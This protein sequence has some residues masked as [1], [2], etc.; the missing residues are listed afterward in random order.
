MCKLVKLYTVDMCRFFVSVKWKF[1]KIYMLNSLERACHIMSVCVCC[2]CKAM[3]SPGD[4]TVLE[5]EVKNMTVRDIFF[6]LPKSQE[7]PGS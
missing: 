2:C 5:G 4:M 6:R 7:S 3:R 1:L